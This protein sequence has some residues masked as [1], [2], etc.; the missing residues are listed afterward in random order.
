[1]DYPALAGLGICNLRSVFG[2]GVRGETL[3]KGDMLGAVRDAGFGR[4]IDLRTA[5][6][7][8]RFAT[9]CA[10]AGLEYHHIP[11]DARKLPPAE[12]QKTLPR[13]FSLLD[14]DG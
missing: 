8:E 7:S 13:L 1:M 10:K 12:L 3:A 5:D 9:R 14:G 2:R 4:I 6:H 11:M